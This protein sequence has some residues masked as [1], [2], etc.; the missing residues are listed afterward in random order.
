MHGQQNIK[1]KKHWVFL[2]WVLPSSQG[3]AAE[4]VVSASSSDE[5]EKEVW[6]TIIHFLLRCFHNVN[7]NGVHVH[8]RNP[9]ATNA[10]LQTAAAQSQLSANAVLMWKLVAPTTE[11]W[12]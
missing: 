4:N 6:T 2:V 12:W 1:K 7:A 8:C 10:S 5:R 9:E 3:A 11:L